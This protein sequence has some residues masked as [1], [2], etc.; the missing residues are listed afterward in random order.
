MECFLLRLQDKVV[1][2]EWE[3]DVIWLDSK[4]GTSCINSLY[5][6]ACDTFPGGVV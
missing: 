4:N 1:N 6:N 5:S 2:G 3:H